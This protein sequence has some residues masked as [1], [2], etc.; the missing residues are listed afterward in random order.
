M[1]KAKEDSAH[2]GRQCCPR[3]RGLKLNV[4]DTKDGSLAMVAHRSAFLLLMVNTYVHSGPQEFLVSLKTVQTTWRD[5]NK[6][7]LFIKFKNKRAMAL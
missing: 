2:C 3:Q 4:Y 7:I 1:F 6:L 5:K